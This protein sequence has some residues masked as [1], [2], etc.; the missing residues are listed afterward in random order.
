VLADLR[1]HYVSALPRSSYR[2]RTVAGVLR[3]LGDP[4]TSYLTPF[5]NLELRQTED[6]A[7][8][9]LGLSLE[10]GGHGLL[11]A[12]RWSRGAA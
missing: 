11:P 7:Y 5:E 1:D 6:G 9:G 10:R 12:G 4:Y 8:G 2:A 3:P